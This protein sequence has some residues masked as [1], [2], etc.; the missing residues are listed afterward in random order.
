MEFSE[1][2][3]RPVETHFTPLFPVGTGLRFAMPV[4]PVPCEPAEQGRAGVRSDLAPGG[5]IPEKRKKED[6]PAV[7]RRTTSSM[8][9]T[10]C[11][12]IPTSR[13]R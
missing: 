5:A 6:H 9:A 7:A 2:E 4:S 8:D 3:D 13:S 11:T 12:G 10:Y 1:Y